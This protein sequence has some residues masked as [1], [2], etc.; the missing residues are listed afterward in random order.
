MD[1][2]FWLTFQN[3]D[4]GYIYPINSTYTKATTAVFLMI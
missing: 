1:C 3:S 2:K 4:E